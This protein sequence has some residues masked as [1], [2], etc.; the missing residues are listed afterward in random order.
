VRHERATNDGEPKQQCHDHRDAEDHE[1]QQGAT[2]REAP[3]NI[4]A[5]VRE[6]LGF[7][8]VVRGVNTRP[9]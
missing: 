8:A 5:C 9:A 2:S 7:E 1:N 3:R 4:S 6:H